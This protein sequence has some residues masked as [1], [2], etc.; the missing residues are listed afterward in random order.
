MSA[1]QGAFRRWLKFNF[2]GAIG[3]C[4]QLVTLTLLKSGLGLNYLLATGIAVEI[5]IIHNFCWHERFTWAERTSNSRFT[6]FVAFNF[7]NGAISLLGNLA[8]MRLLTGVIGVNYFPAS[9]A[10]IAACSLLNFAVSDHFVFANRS[11]R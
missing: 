8:V 5:T 4:V 6:R 7:S 9:L 3:I 10:G 11:T 1:P 2:V